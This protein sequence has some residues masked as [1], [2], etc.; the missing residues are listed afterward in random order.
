MIWIIGG[1]SEGREIADRIKDLDNYIITAATDESREFIQD[2]N[3]RVGRMS[4]DEM[5]Q[6]SLENNIS[7]IVDLTH[8]FAKIVSDNAKKLADQLGIKYVRYSRERVKKRLSS[9]FLNS[10]EEAYEYLKDVKGTVF[11]T[12][13][14]K[15]IADFEKVRGDNRF[16]YR[17]LPATESLDICKKN[18]ILMKDIVAVLGPFSVKYNMAMFEEYGAD[19]VIMKDSGD[20]GGTLEKI[21]ACESLN[22]PAIIIGRE[23]EQGLNDLDQVEKI[24][25]EEQTE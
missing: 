18:N 9:I 21:K 10:Y 7:L 8:P 3:I 5:W 20:K 19:Y 24:I 1:T 17:I 23:E 12:T 16:I 25:R 2:G 4:Y 14:S 13:G 11:L 6:F 15:N 22:I